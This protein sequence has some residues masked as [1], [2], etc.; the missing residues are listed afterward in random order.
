MALKAGNMSEDPS[1]DT[2]DVAFR[3]GETA[4]SWTTP[5]E[6]FALL[7]RG[8]TFSTAAPVALVVGTVLSLVN[9]L[10]VMVQ[11][12]ATSATW[13]RVATNYVVPYIVSSIGFLSACRLRPRR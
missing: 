3:V 9:Q 12:D 1:P 11:G 10:N 2:D 8:V 5:R 6:A 13:A 4:R 7:C